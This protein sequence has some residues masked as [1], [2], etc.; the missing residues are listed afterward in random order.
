MG[1]RLIIYLPVV[2]VMSF[3]FL[4]FLF[5]SLCPTHFMFGEGWGGGGGCPS[6]ASG[7]LKKER[8]QGRDTDK[9]DKREVIET[10]RD[11]R[12]CVRYRCQE[13]EGLAAA[14]FPLVLVQCDISCTG[15]AQTTING[16]N[17]RNY[18][19]HTVRTPAGK[20]R[21]NR[22]ERGST[23]LSTTQKA[24]TNSQSISVG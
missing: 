15:K 23:G 7:F 12:G 16:R 6:P 17:R 1:T 18:H 5:R 14:C 22:L 11:Q 10:C 3:F 24:V 21:K 4:F 20:K 2:S 9:D 19:H 8:K 13:S